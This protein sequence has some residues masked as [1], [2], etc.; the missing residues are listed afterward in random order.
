LN[1]NYPINIKKARTF[2]ILFKVCAGPEVDGRSNMAAVL[3][4]VVGTFL[5]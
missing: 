5:G 2:E 3:A 1:Y 4:V